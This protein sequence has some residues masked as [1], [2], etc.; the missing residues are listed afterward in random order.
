MSFSTAWCA[1]ALSI[2]QSCGLDKVGSMWG[3]W[4]GAGPVSALLLRGEAFGRGVAWW[5]R[6]PVSFMMVE[7]GCAGGGGS[8]GGG[9]SEAAVGVALRAFPEPW[10]AVT[11]AC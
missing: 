9:T 6:A 10:L 2:C 11:T 4:A 1:N 5:C 7:E 3:A 8:G